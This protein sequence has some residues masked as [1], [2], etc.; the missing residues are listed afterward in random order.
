[1]FGGLFDGLFGGEDAAAQNVTTVQAQ[2]VTVIGPEGEESPQEEIEMG[3][4]ATAGSG[5]ELKEIIAEIVKVPAQQAAGGSSSN[6]GVEAKLEELIGLL[7]AG[8]I[9]VN[10]DGRKVESQLAKV[11]P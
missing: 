5:E 7:K 11:A 4:I 8:K 3:A 6:A 1:M 9:G 10:M 2:Q